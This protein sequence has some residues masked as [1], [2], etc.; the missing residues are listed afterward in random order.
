MVYESAVADN[1][2]FVWL[3]T[4][5]KS[6]ARRHCRALVLT[7]WAAVVA[8][9]LGFSREEPLSLGCRHQGNRAV[10]TYLEGKFGD[11]LTAARDAM[12]TLAGRFKPDALRCE[13][14]RLYEQF[15]PAIPEGVSGWG[16]KGVLDL[17]HIRRLAVKAD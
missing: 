9:R 4:K 2:T 7:L 12:M 13:A 17:G 11:D 5:F 10:K 16:A 14:F 1:A 3:K 15:R 8:E 6:T